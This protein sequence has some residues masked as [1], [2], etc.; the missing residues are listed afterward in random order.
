M[1]GLVPGMLLLLMP[2]CPA[3]LATYVTLAFGLSLTVTDAETLRL[4]TLGCLVLL[5]VAVCGSFFAIR[6][7]WSKRA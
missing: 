5:L 7:S 1:A 3:C 2:K 6:L 4:V